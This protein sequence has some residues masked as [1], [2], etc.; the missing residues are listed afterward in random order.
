[1]VISPA[2]FTSEENPP[3][4]EPLKIAKVRKRDGRI[5]DLD[6]QRIA[7]AIFKAARAV[8]GRDRAEA[9]KLAEKVADCLESSLKPGAVP[10][11]E[12]IQDVVEKILIEAGHAKT[13]K[14]YILYRQK[15]AEIR[16]QKQRV[17]EKDEVDEVD[18][19]FDVNALRV[20]KARYL[21]KDEAGGLIET[22]KQLFTRV[23]V[24]TSL[25]SPLYDPSV[26][27]R[28]GKQPSHPHEEFN[29]AEN[30][31]KYWIGKYALNR[32]HLEALKRIYERFDSEGK[33]RINWS[34]LLNQI[35]QG[36]FDN[37][38]AEIDRFYN[39]M[40]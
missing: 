32:Y 6:K 14:A 38:G 31:G 30:D 1:L 27:D 2:Q 15:R 24:H 10:G 21:R 26:F 11:V 20:L 25:P 22:P 36:K 4:K 35:S 39:I 40:V 34:E 33:M 13:A 18:K 16:K 29:P 37:Y 19:T 28:A 5:V 12:E 8:G 23:A 9:D 3:V 17:L 7:N